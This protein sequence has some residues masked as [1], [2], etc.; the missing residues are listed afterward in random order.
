MASFTSRHRGETR[1][2]PGT[3]AVPWLRR[4]V[5][6]APLAFVTAAA[7]L[8]LAQYFHL[9]PWDYLRNDSLFELQAWLTGE[10]LWGRLHHNDAA[11]HIQSLLLALDVYV[12]PYALW[13]R[14]FAVVASATGF[15]MLGVGL[16]RTIGWERGV[17][18]LAV[19]VGFWLAPANDQQKFSYLWRTVE[20]GC[21]L[22]CLGAAS[23]VVASWSRGRSTSR[24]VALLLA[25]LFVF[26]HAHKAFGY[27]LVIVLLGAL[28]LPTRREKGIYAGLGIGYLIYGFALEGSL[29]LL[30]PSGSGESTSLALVWG[31]ARGTAAL[32]SAPIG[33]ALSGLLSEGPVR[34]ARA[35]GVALV[36]GVAGA[37]AWR[38][39][40]LRE[41]GAVLSLV[42]LVV[43]LGLV[44]AT[45]LGRYGTFGMEIAS[46]PRYW[47]DA[48]LACFG[49]VVFLGARA[50][51]PVFWASAA[52]LLGLALLQ[53]VLGFSNIPGLA[54]S[55]QLTES[56]LFAH[57]IHPD[58][59]WTLG[60]FDARHVRA[61]DDVKAVAV[62]EGVGVLG[63]PAF[64]RRDELE[65][66]AF[67]GL[68]AC[69]GRLDVVRSP[70]VGSVGLTFVSGAG[71]ERAWEF[72][73]L[74][75]DGRL[76]GFGHELELEGRRIVTVIAPSEAREGRL[77]LYG[78]GPGGTPEPRC[79]VR[80]A[81]SRGRGP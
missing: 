22:L 75:K 49:A 63:L 58:R 39:W 50:S 21:H 16:V 35:T 14:S 43:N 71:E 3:D 29:A 61:F 19:L 48:L 59:G 15:T 2:R 32:V 67:D 74:W 7:G 36:G 25:V 6:L 70:R 77:L 18:L 31:Y 8:Q 4:L 44:A 34:V 52:P 68:P 17:V 65:P 42:V 37:A 30:I 66:P 24:G 60:S 56:L 13:S 20:I 62:T 10:S 38:V 11:S 55:V 26:S 41:G 79:R 9:V 27:L 5:F 33:D 72:A 1:A 54:R 28:L 78:T 47:S 73:V 64:R 81:P 46:V 53:A 45:V 23:L 76:M 40:T 80:L 51:A 12:G 69:P 57:V